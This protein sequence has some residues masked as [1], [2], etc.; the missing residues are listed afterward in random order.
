ML[1]LLLQFGLGFLAARQCFYLTKN[2]Y[3]LAVNT[4]ADPRQQQRKAKSLLIGI[5]RIGYSVYT[6]SQF[7][8]LLI[9]FSYGKWIIN[10]KMTS[11]GTRNHELF[12]GSLAQAWNAYPWEFSVHYKGPLSKIL[13]SSVDLGPLLN[14]HLA[15]NSRQETINNFVIGRKVILN[16][17][18]VIE[19]PHKIIWTRLMA[20]KKD[21]SLSADISLSPRL[22]YFAYF[23]LLQQLPVIVCSN[24]LLWMQLMPLVSLMQNFSP[25][26]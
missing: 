20:Y 19:L 10:A 7:N 8:M 21:N 22:F 23:C 16:T 4:Y 2:R 25:L 3:K 18:F 13:V 9:N 11:K 17:I 26:S 14:D 6:L 5:G 1:Q 15:I 12:P 24:H